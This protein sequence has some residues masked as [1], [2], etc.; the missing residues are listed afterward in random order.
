METILIYKLEQVTSLD[1]ANLCCH[2]SEVVIFGNTTIAAARNF[3]TLYLMDLSLASS[4]SSVGRFSLQTVNFTSMASKNRFRACDLFLAI[5][6]PPLLN[7]FGMAYCSVSLS[8]VSTDTFLP[9]P[10]HPLGACEL[11]D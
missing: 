8:S 11:I 6:I 7:D 4:S 3:A 10:K 2:T 5:E 1:P 9:V